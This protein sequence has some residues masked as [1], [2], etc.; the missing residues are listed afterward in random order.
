MP[1]LPT[2]RYPAEERPQWA[3]SRMFAIP[4]RLSGN[5]EYPL[6]IGRWLDFQGGRGLPPFPAGCAGTPPRASAAPK[7][8]RP[9]GA[10]RHIGWSGKGGQRSRGVRRGQGIIGDAQGL[11]DLC[12]PQGPAFA[13]VIGDKLCPSSNSSEAFPSLE[14]AFARGMTPAWSASPLGA[15]ETTATDLWCRSAFPVTSLVLKW[16][17]ISSLPTPSWTTASRC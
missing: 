1:R 16:L 13:D 10:G 6:A 17:K 5:C 14:R 12:V 7:P 4:R 3:V 11:G 8:N 15:P 9:C 2:W